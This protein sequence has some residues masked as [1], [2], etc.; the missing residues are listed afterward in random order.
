MYTKSVYVI[1]FILAITD[2]IFTLKACAKI[3]EN[4]AKWLKSTLIAGI[5]AIIANIFIALSINPLMAETSYILYFI[6]IDWILYCLT[7]FCIYYTEHSK[8][9]FF[10][11]PI[12]ASV[13]AADSISLV[14]NLIFKHCFSIYE[15]T[16]SSG[17]V[18]Y[19]TSFNTVYYI[20]LAVDY[21]AI[22]FA[23]FFIVLKIKKTYSFYRTKYIM[24]LSVLIL[25]VVLN[26]IYMAFGLVLD[27]S[28][29]FYAVAATL[30]YFSIAV[31]VPR[32]LLISAIGRAVD[33][34]NEGLIIFDLS[35]DCIYANKYSRSKFNHETGKFTLDME[36]LSSV[37]DIL[38]SANKSFGEADY[39]KQH[40][41]KAENYRIKYNNLTDQKG[42]NIGSYFLIE[43]T[44]EAEYYL[45]EIKQARENA[46]KAN[47]AKSTFLANM[48]HEI[49]TPLNS[50]LGM[51]EMILRS[52]DDALIK[53]YAQNIRTSGDTLLNLINDILDFSK[54]E[55]NRMEV[56]PVEYEPH[57]LIHEC[58]D[59]FWQAA[60]AKDLYLNIKCAEDLPRLLMGDIQHIKQIV[61]N[62]VSNAIKYTDQG[63][64]TIDVSFNNTDKDRIDLC[65]KV[66][67][68][69]KGIAKEDVAYLFD[70]F[71]RIN[72]KQNATIQGTGLG[73]AITKNLVD[74]MN[75]KI[76]VEST[77]GK[78][79]C[80][81]VIL[82]QEVIDSTPSGTYQNTK[83]IEQ[84]EYKESFTAPDANIL[85]VDDVPLN[86]KVAEALLKKTLIHVDKAAGGNE[87]IDK[88]LKIKYDLILLDHRMPE[89]DGV[90]VFK[91]ISVEGANTDTPVIMLTANALE[92]A[93]EEYKKIGF[94]GYLSKPI[95]SEQLENTLKANLPSDKI[96]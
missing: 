22:L 91:K 45:R 53:E 31:F 65:V 93:E 68:T 61:S 84:Q 92:G 25:V 73:L 14:L 83:Y 47:Q 1:V 41:I 57:K 54:I 87:A 42:R 38:K 60:G 12:A 71:K 29:I 8:E 23:L 13:M 34:M 20:H 11:S 80:F 66:T 89:P 50:V 74:L 78:G 3:Q 62:L 9:L 6:S 2:M 36:P 40:G 7:G 16:D 26:V 44:T 10:L 17:S 39:V 27:A 37:I 4:Y 70:A 48:S 15:I 85:I 63:G 32:N 46:D 58:N 75:G 56:I 72:E 90:E 19:Q 55:A 33:D 67:D 59:F 69:G 28:V 82:P 96:R 81:A 21:I 30:I 94:A 86:L 64:V 5:V 51:N 79:S 43:D 49:R 76:E 35:N 95:K 77:P 18:F 88:C 52:T 24:I